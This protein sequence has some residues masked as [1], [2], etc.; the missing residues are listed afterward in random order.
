[1]KQS[2]SGQ[3]WVP[4][5][6]K[7]DGP[8][9]LAIASAIGA[10]IASG[11]LLAGA[12]LP[13]QRAL[14]ELMGID[15]TTISRAYNEA[16]RRGLIEGR[17]GQGTYVR[18]RAPGQLQPMAGIVD[19]SMNLPPRFADDGL[20]RR[21]WQDIASVQGDDGLDLLL[22]Y[23]E[24]GGSAADRAAGAQWLAPVLPEVT[25]ERL[26]V[27]PGAQGALMAVIGHLAKPGDLVCAEALTYPG[28]KALAAYLGLRV[29]ALAMDGEGILPE[30]FESAC[31]DEKPKALYCTP[32]LHNPTTATMSLE[33]RQ[34]IAEIATRFGVPIVEDDAYALLPRNG[35]APL[36][37]FAPQLTYYVAS[38]AKCLSPALRVAY[39]VVPDMRSVG[40]LAGNIRA[41]TAIA[42]PLTA[43]IAT[44]WIDTGVAASILRAI[45][46]ESKERQRMLSRLLP[47][48]IAHQE[49]FH[50][51]L[52]LGGAWDR[53]SFSAKLRSVGIGVVPSDAFAM[54]EAP[55]AVRLGL[56]SVVSRTD[57]EASL[58][59]IADI[60]GQAPALT[61]MVV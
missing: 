47:D 6:S 59:M 22:R 2:E 5:V 42:S 27:T 38:L 58:N 19:M 12:R 13:P 61:S 29:R 26:L 33:R 60:L 48:A 39:L 1:M 32:T 40:R 41:S 21:M 17:V 51:W 23:Q 55:E 43:A 8:L 11:R 15:F 4:A 14:A 52:P 50:A 25:P 31:R 10:D 45:Q 34:A 9:Y 56:G 46:Q 36:A 28:F 16:R 53:H 20:V 24:A 49:A 37:S 44:R 7:A 54:A 3:I 35:L 18:A 30:A 57:L